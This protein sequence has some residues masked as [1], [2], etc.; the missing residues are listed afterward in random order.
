MKRWDSGLPLRALRA[1][2][3]AIDQVVAG[4][5]LGASTENADAIVILGATVLPNG[6]ASGSLRARVEM[7]A[8]LFF[9]G[10]APIVVATG[11]HHRQPPGEAVVSRQILL[12][13]GVPAA[14]ILIEEKSRNTSGNL[15]F[16]RG[17]LPD[18]RRI[19]LVTEPFHMARAMFLAR[20]HGFAE[21]LPV[22]VL[23]PAWGRPW[24]RFRL[25]ARDCFSMAIARGEHTFA[26]PE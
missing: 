21:A 25:T 2:P 5:R 7:A 11:A 19:L 22:P 17:L 26:A 20:V 8:E 3:N 13:R 9:A 4:T 15:L 18:A 24:D 6:E 14:A 10:R 23:S 12:G 1:F 16:A